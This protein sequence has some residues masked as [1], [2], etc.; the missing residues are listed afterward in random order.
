MPGLRRFAAPLL[1]GLLF[2]CPGADDEPEPEP[3]AWS[4]AFSAD[5]SVGA[6]LSVWGPSPDDVWAVGGQVEDVRAAGAGSAVRRRGGT[7]AV[8]ELPAGTPLLNWVHG[9]GDRVWV[10]GNAGAALRREGDAWVAT[11]SGVDVAL[12]G[13]WANGPSDVW[14][15]GGDAFDLEGDPV[16]VHW[17]G[18]AW[19]PATWPELD[20]RS[21][22]FFKVWASGAADVWVVGDGGVV[23]H[24]DGSAWAQVPSGTNDDLISLW[25][26]GDGEILAV[27]GRQLGVLARWDGAAWTAGEVDRALGLNGVWMDESGNASI[28]GNRGAAGEV[29]AGALQ[30][31][32]EDVGA[33]VMVLHGVFGFADGERIAVGGSLDR[34][35]PWTG[36]ILE[37]N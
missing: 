34:A 36:L 32:L 10:V 6:L 33:G 18:S 30:A 2:G 35:P 25:G 13:V 15:V 26:T 27:G 17:D 28:V 5:A 8:D 3:G 29:E 20:R 9:E 37:T 22:A 1:I 4:Q 7:W 31:T 14:A 24:F 16:I 12:W 21:S 23:L 19:T 11:D